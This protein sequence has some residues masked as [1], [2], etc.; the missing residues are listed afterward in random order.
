MV[1]RILHIDLD[2]FF[3]SVERALDPSLRG[4]P[5]VVGGNPAARGVV[6]SASYEA[7]AFGLRAGMPLRQ[8]YRLCPHAIFLEGSF[9]RYR[10]A[11]ARFIEILGDFTPQLEPA[12][13]DEAYLDLTGF[14]PIYG[15]V[16][17]VAL[18]IKRRITDE[19][20]LTASVGIAT[21]KVV[22]KVASGLAKPDGLIEVMPGEERLF[23]AP[24]E[25]GRLPCVG[26]RTEQ[27]LK[28]MGITIIGELA[29]LPPSFLK[30]VFG[31][32]G[33]LMYRYA[34]GIDDRKV[35]PPSPVKQISRETTFA[36]DTLDRRLLRA[37]L[38]YLSE[39]VGS[40]LRAQGRCARCIT[41]KLRYA[42]F[43]SITRS[44]TIGEGTDLDQ[45]IFDIGTQLL[46]KALDHRRQR[47]RL[48][49]IGVSKLSAGGRQLNM[50][51]LSAQRMTYL[52]RAI[53]R[54][55]RK[56]GFT[57]IQTGRTMPLRDFSA[58][59]NGDYVLK[60]PSLSR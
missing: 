32:A 57:A 1:R 25:I 15:P 34:N 7:R 26:A 12:G 36:D 45:V 6:A 19:M 37:T 33:E 22:A 52:N 27:R 40:E 21:S 29:R 24:L 14:E 17:D 56:Y 41:L 5:V 47:V 54:I 39:R 49:G 46:E 50:L 38:C 8:A 20:K 30:S 9:P 10:D 28:E 44:R 35:E 16:R 53:D 3:V 43:E 11:S 4:K 55:R 18:R 60:T 13:I 31:G 23:L 2:A 48:I 58:I 51:D 42:D 59:E